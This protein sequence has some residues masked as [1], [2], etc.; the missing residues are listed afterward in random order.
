LSQDFDETFERL[1]A[2]E[3]GVSRKQN[4]SLQS[5]LFL[6]AFAAFAAFAL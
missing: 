2:D 5:L 1:R 3:E 6:A 4:Q